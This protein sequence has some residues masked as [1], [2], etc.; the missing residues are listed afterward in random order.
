MIV[1]ASG[2]SMTKG[3][4]KSFCSVRWVVTKPGATTVT[5]TPERSPA[6]SA[7]RLSHM[8][9]RNALVAP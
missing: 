1:A 4:S 8:L 7:R 6:R 9:I 2:A 5:A 3:I